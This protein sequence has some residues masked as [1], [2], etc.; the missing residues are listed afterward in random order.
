MVSDMQ[1]L[2]TN[3]QQTDVIQSR[4][5]VCS[6]EW[7]R[8]M[9]LQ[10][11]TTQNVIVCRGGNNRWLSVFLQYLICWKK[12]KP[13]CACIAGDGEDLVTMSLSNNIWYLHETITLN[14]KPWNNNIP[15]GVSEMFL[16]VK[17]T[18]QQ[19]SAA[20]FLMLGASHSGQTS[21][22]CYIKYRGLIHN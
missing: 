9:L 13:A 22:F 4:M 10:S 6:A 16:F 20:C 18:N 12:S 19:P 17:R 1:T 15:P 14:N 7:L 8:T 21:R 3:Q 2:S 11:Q 5:M